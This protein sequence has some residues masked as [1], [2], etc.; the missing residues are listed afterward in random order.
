MIYCIIFYTISASGRQKS[1]LSN[2]GK[3][4]YFFV[5]FLISYSVFQMMGVGIKLFGSIGSF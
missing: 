5:L 1:Q 4:T 3:L 2:Y